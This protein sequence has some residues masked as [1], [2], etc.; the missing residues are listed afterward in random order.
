MTEE[1]KLL[2]SGDGGIDKTSPTTK[3]T[4]LDPKKTRG[5]DIIDLWI[6]VMEKRLKELEEAEAALYDEVR[7]HKQPPETN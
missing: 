5:T 4:V 6:S 2:K 1:E 3:F 7:A